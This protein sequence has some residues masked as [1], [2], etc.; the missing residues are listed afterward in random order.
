MTKAFSNEL[1]FW[2]EFDEDMVTGTEENKASPTIDSSIISADR[3][4]SWCW[5]RLERNWRMAG[6]MGIVAL[7]VQED[8]EAHEVKDDGDEDD[9]KEDGEAHEEGEIGDE[10]ESSE[11]WEVEME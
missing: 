11:K 7:V 1:K 2:D 8:G 3:N 5:L 4:E 9:L 6:F 10:Q